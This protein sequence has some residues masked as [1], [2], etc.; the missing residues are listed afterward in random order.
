MN[1]PL[2]QV[3]GMG[4]LV[5]LIHQDLLGIRF[6]TLNLLKANLNQQTFRH[7]HSKEAMQGSGL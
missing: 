4:G 3:G 2:V 6:V 5:L 7:G 1:K